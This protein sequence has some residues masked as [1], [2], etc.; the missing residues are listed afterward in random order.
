MMEV[1]WLHGFDP[2]AD[3]LLEAYNTLVKV[4]SRLFDSFTCH[5]VAHLNFLCISDLHV[6]IW[7]FELLMG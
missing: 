7:L 4:L 5:F 3:H 1:S 6:M 2:A